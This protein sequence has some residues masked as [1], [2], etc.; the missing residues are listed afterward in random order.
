MRIED[1]RVAHNTAYYDGLDFARQIGDD[2]AA[3]SGGEKAMIGAFNA[4]RSCADGSRSA[5][6]RVLSN[7]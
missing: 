1:D 4:G 7:G 6:A 2:A 5:D 3:E